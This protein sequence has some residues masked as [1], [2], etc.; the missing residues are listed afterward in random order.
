[1]VILKMQRNAGDGNEASMTTSCDGNDA[2]VATAGGGKA[3]CAP[4]EEPNSPIVATIL[5]PSR[6]LIKVFFRSHS[7]SGARDKSGY[8]TL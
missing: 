7:I 2:S 5:Y 6:I 4:H 1:M 8:I 3:S